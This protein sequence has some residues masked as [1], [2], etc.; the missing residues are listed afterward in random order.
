VLEQV[1][2][3]AEVAETETKDASQ[4]LV[5]PLAAALLAGGA[6]G[7][8]V[9]AASSAHPLGGVFELVQKIQ[10]LF[11]QVS[12]Q[13]MIPLIN[14][15]AVAPIY[16][17]SWNEAVGNLRS[18]ERQS[19]VQTAQNFAKDVI[20]IAADPAFVNRTLIG[21]MRGTQELSPEDQ[22]RLARMLK[23][24]LI[25]VSL[26]LLYSVEVGKVNKGEF[27][28]IEPE[29]LRDLILGRFTQPAGPGKKRSLQEELTA[30]LIDRV[31]EQLAPL[32]KED[33]EFAAGLLVE[34]VTQPRELD[35][36]LDPVK[37]FDE[38]LSSSLF[39]TLGKGRG[40]KA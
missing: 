23:I 40:I 10:P 34:Y 28:G 3:S 39:D 8:G 20:K 32:S 12:L 15:M 37:V 38:A 22:E 6:A 36:M 13:D 26:S 19:F 16:Y 29:E 25:G 35:P 21:R 5:L 18:G 14:L 11:P 1:P 31:H 2:P 24:V 9:Q 7:L 30:S 33:R 17:N 27:G 4:V